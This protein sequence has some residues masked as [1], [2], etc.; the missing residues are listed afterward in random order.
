M[1]PIFILCAAMI[2]V[3]SK[4][5]ASI[6]DMSVSGV[7]EPCGKWMV[8]FDWSDM[9]EY[10]KSVSHGDNEAGRIKV[11]TDTLIITSAYDAG[12]VIKIAITKYSAKDDSL[13]NATSMAKLANETLLKSKVCGERS[14]SPRVID[15]KSGIFVSGKR[16]SDGEP[17]F[18][19]VYPVNYCF[20]GP[21]GSL[22]SSAVAVVSSTFKPETTERLLNT[23][24][25]V[26]TS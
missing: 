18:V 24:R 17:V 4:A 10:K 23:L 12:K 25:I 3:L 14:L 19:C 2:L 8:T 1:R 13:V 5:A 21:G 11:A 26:Q 22:P 7:S 6:D 9:D 20:D 16:C 15:G